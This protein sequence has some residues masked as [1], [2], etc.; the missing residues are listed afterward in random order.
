MTVVKTLPD[1]GRQPA[2]PPVLTRADWPIAAAMIQFPSVLPDGTSVQDQSTEGW[3]ASLAEVADA[4]FDCVDPTDS[5][6]R[7]ADLSPTRRHEFMAVAAE[8]G[9]RIPAISTA[10]RSVI[11][12][13]R[14]D[15]Y[16]AYTHRVVDAAAEV[17]A[18]V[19]STGFFE[20]LNS[21]QRDALW[22]WTAQG[23]VNPDDPE[24]WALAV[25][26]VIELGRHAAEV[27][28]KISLEMYE[29]TYLGTA[30]S[31]V[32][33]ISDVNAPN[34]GLNPDLGNLVRL[35]RPVEH[36]E[37]MARKVLPY[38]N[39]WHVKNYFR[40]EDATDGR[41]STMPAPLEF[42]VI[43][44]RRAVKM[45]VDEGFRGPITVEHYGGDGLSVSAVNRD[46]LRRLLPLATPP[47]PNPGLD[48]LHR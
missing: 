41:V 8:V 34:V 39:F 2:P 11:D 4:G 20:A 9:L 38:A 17:G 13:I 14:G 25:A 18:M 19:V 46:Y 10:R 36:W 32:R 47:G 31:A 45:A 12:P 48:H 1:S 30:D 33:F 37:S 29:D 26:R 28:I 44:Y 35:H 5:W 42:G 15:E 27:G 7:I 24:V 6:L 21:A 23:P 22:F 40:S 3:Q 43:N 16:L